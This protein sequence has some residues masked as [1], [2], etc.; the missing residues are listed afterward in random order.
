MTAS[1]RNS[2]FRGPLV[3][4]VLAKFQQCINLSEIS[5]GGISNCDSRSNGLA[6]LF[7]FELPLLAI[8]CV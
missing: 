3:E 8:L 5:N 2:P 7:L 6:G 1:V 4:L